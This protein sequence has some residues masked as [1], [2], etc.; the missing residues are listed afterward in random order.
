MFICFQ[1]AGAQGPPGLLYDLAT[2]KSTCQYN[3]YQTLTYLG[4]LSV[5]FVWIAAYYPSQLTSIPTEARWSLSGKVLGVFS[6]IT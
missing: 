2:R 3:S 4:I 6:V 1:M 5:I